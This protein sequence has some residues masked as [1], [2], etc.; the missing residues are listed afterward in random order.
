MADLAPHSIHAVFV[1]ALASFDQADLSFADLILVLAQR[2]VTSLADVD[3]EVPQEHAE[4]LKLWFAEE[5][6]SESHRRQ[7]LGSVETEAQASAS[8][9][10]LARLTAKVTAVLKSDNEY[11]QEI[12][13][14]AERDPAVL[15]ERANRLLKA[16]AGSLSEAAGATRE[17]AIVVD[18]LEKLSN[19][20]VVDAA[21]LRRADDFRRLRC[22]LVLFF[23]TADEYAPET[24]RAGDAFQIKTVPMLPVRGRDDQPDH[25]APEVVNALRELV[26]RRVDLDSVFDPP[27]DCL[28]SVARLSGG[29]LRDVFHVTQLACDLAAPER[30]TAAH[31]EAAG[32]RLGAERATL[33]KPDKWPRLAEIHRDKQVANDPADGYLI[34][35]SL[36]LNYDES[37]PLW[38]DVHPLVRLDRRFDVAWRNLSPSVT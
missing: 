2:V 19:R 1:N 24:V 34:L 33:V 25:V 8:V 18:N 27:D 20:R 5:L 21:V 32:R 12:R 17:I 14:R 10:F 16:A 37:V 7:I 28:R 3:V 35:H 23:D 4:L 15:V 36:V 13:R 26:G 22:H 38:W 6:L 29:R 31:V 30:V 9:S 11:R